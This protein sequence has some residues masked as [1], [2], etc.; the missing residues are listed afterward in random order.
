MAKKR[1]VLIGYKGKTKKGLRWAV[2]NDT[3]HK[4]NIEPFKTIDEA[5]AAGA[6]KFTPMFTRG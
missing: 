5:R 3:D 4:G 1:S 2:I 6:T